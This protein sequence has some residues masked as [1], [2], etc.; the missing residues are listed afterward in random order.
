M[1]NTHTFIVIILCYTLLAGCSAKENIYKGIFD[2]S[3][4]AKY[5]KSS[6][7]LPPP[8][9]VNSDY[10]QYKREREELLKKEQ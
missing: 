6:D 9:Q 4:R 10:D 2:S 5:L 8:E 3:N 1:K 7:E